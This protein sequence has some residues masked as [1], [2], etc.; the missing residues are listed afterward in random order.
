MEGGWISRL[1]RVPKFQAAAGGP[2]YR[3]CRNFTVQVTISTSVFQPITY[4]TGR[5]LLNPI[6]R[7][8]P[9]P[10]IFGK[11]IYRTAN[12][13][14]P[15][16]MMKPWNSQEISLINLQPYWYIN[17]LKIM[18]KSSLASLFEHD[19]LWN[20]NFL[21]KLFWYF[22]FRLKWQ[23]WIDNPNPKSDFDFGLSITIKT[24][25]FLI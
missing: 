11:K 1:T 23:N 8:N 22:G 20:F 17:C 15:S 4:T 3:R 6:A 19:A 16:F 24:I 21:I 9:N 18:I 5:V 10:T 14:W 2:S 13:K 12:I 7:S 25:I